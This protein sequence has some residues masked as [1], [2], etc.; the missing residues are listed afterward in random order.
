MTID[1][2]RVGRTLGELRRRHVFRTVAVYAIAAWGVLEVADIV[3]P[4]LLFPSW[5]MTLLVVIAIIGFPLTA[6]LAWIYDMTSEGV[7]RTAESAP[8][9]NTDRAFP[10]QWSWRWLDFLIIV[11][12]AAILVFVLVRGAG[13]N[14]RDQPERS[15]AVLPFTD[16]SPARDTGYFC[17]GMAEAILDALAPLSG[18]QVA[19]RTS[20]FSFRDTDAREVARKLGV[21]TLLEGSVRKDGDRIRISARLVDGRTGHQLWSETYDRTLDDVFAV[22]DSISRAIV[23]VLRVQVLDE[24]QL[25]EVPTGDQ[26]AYEEYLRGRDQLRNGNTVEDY[27]LAIDRFERALVLDES[28]GLARAG[29]C[30]AYWQQ[31]KLV[32][33]SELADQAI[34]ACREAQA[35]SSRAETLVA[36][37]NVYRETGRVADSRELFTRALQAEPNN[38]NAHAGLAQALRRNGDL[39]S[40]GHH[41]RRAIDLDPAYWHHHVALARVLYEQGRVDDTISEL[42][43]AIRLAPDNPV[44]YISLAAVHYYE[45][46]YLRAAE[47]NRQ[48]LE[49]N[50]TPRG[51]SNAGSYYFYAGEYAQAEAMYRRAIELFSPGRFL[52]HGFLAEA[53]EMQPENDPREIAEQYELATRLGY[54]RLEVN[55]TD[56]EARSLVAGYLAKTGRQAEALSE[57]AR[58]EQIEDLDMFAHRAAG[59]AYLELG[60]TEKAVDHFEDAVAKG[61]PTQDLAG[62]PRLRPLTDNATFLALV[63]DRADSASDQQGDNQ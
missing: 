21:G 26:R 54:E 13:E 45:G 2:S 29:I 17:D 58:L 44:P 31:Y 56:H 42:D 59:F 16:L 37:G 30:T 14:T 28:F 60:Q 61:L 18:L 24:R 41:L 6:V 9:P 23:D 25:V 20:S 3:L 48:S 46:D 62:D 50:P 52:W 36:L 5:A 47:I 38:A 53:L 49:R 55:P 63:S 39:E 12:L 34:A 27:Q 32:G 1:R 10:F 57:L 33:D 22:Q 19:A 43:Q 40:A 11:T 7:V 51:Y 15:I 35:T 8:G 4:A